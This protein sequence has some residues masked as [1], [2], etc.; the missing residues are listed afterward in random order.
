VL[1]LKGKP[2]LLR[3]PETTDTPARGERR[4]R[5]RCPLC[6][7]EP[8][9]HDVWMCLCG[10]VWNT[11]ATGGVCPA[12]SRKWEETQCLRCKEWSPHDAW[13]EDDPDRE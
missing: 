6:A 7:W 2:D 8:G 11:F 1:L 3:P 10:H 13:Y 9:R 12:C 5:I 4:T